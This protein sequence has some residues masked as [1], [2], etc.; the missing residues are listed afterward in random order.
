M[1]IYR[2]EGLFFAHVYGGLTD[3]FSKPYLISLNGVC[4]SSYCVT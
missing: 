3:T 2:H 4:Q 1:Q